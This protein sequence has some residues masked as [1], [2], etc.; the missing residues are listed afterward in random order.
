[1]IEP[2][3]NRTELPRRSFPQLASGEQ[4]E[5]NLHLNDPI[6]YEGWLPSEAQ[7][8]RFCEQLRSEPEWQEQQRKFDERQSD[9]GAEAIVSMSDHSS[10]HRRTAFNGL[11]AHQRNPI[12]PS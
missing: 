8:R 12:R 1:M 2:N 6:P 11:T 3:L 5:A 7:I 9:S 4:L 10:F